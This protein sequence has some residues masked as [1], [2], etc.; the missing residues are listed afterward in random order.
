[1]VSRLPSPSPPFSEE[2]FAE[3]IGLL[4]FFFNLWQEE[5]ISDCSTLTSWVALFGRKT[6]ALHLRARGREQ[7][8]VTPFRRPKNG[9]GSLPKL[10]PRTLLQR[11]SLPDTTEHMWGL[12]ENQGR[13]LTASSPDV[14][15]PLLWSYMWERDCHQKGRDTQQGGIQE[16]KEPCLWFRE[17]EHLTD[18]VGAGWGSCQVGVSVF[19]LRSS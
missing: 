6:Q 11:L 7:G 15:G 10:S 17:Q 19:G 3:H 18:V 13:F 12:R 14:A 5:I 1:M 16:S 9:A 8:W 4:L 2:I